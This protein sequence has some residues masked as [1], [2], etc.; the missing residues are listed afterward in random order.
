[1]FRRRLRRLPF[2]R[3]AM[4]DACAER[5]LRRVIVAAPTDDAALSA[6]V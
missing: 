6:F 5:Y 1:M 3:H 2:A 4:L